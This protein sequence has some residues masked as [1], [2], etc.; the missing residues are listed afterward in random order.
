[1]PGVKIRVVNIDAN[2]AVK[3]GVSVGSQNVTP[4]ADDGTLI[5]NPAMLHQMTGM[6][7]PPVK[8]K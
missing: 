7:T 2:P 4:L 1:M 3:P 5:V 6:N 8:P